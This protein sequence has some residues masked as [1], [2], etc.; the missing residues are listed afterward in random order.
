MGKSEDAHRE[1]KVIQVVQEL[2]ELF[3]IL[4]RDSLE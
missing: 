1:G 2:A 3:E 4:E